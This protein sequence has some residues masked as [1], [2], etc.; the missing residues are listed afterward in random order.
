MTPTRVLEALGLPGAWHFYLLSIGAMVA[1]AGLDFIGAIFAKEWSDHGHM[2]YFF[3]GLLSFGV[4][5]GVYA[6]SLKVA[7]LSTVTF[8]WV[9]LLQVGILILERVRYDVELPPGKWV[10]I[11]AILVLQAYLILAPNGAGA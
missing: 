9:V 10:A 11:T 2:T 4:L 5:F 3:A 7:E 1:L 8:G 6:A